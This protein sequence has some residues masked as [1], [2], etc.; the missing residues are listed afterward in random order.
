[1]PTTPPPQIFGLFFNQDG[2]SKHFLYE[3]GKLT[4]S[5]MSKPENVWEAVW[6][7]LAEDAEYQARRTLGVPV[8]NAKTS[9]SYT[10]AATQ[11]YVS[12]GVGR[13]NTML[14]KGG[15]ESG[16]SAITSWIPDPVIEIY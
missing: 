7:H 15:D 16:K 1:M 4:S 8:S 2:R 3:Y 12:D 14:K 10:A 9:R 11:G 13:S 5:S 6:I